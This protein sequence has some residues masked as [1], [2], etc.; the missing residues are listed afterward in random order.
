VTNDQLADDHN[1]RLALSSGLQ[2]ARDVRMLTAVGAWV[3]EDEGG[4][5]VEFGFA[6]REFLFE[7]AFA[8][9]TA[10]GTRGRYLTSLGGRAS[11]GRF[12]ASGRWAFDYEFSQNRM[13]G[14]SSANDDLPQHRLRFSRDHAWS[15]W[16]LSWRLEALVYDDENALTLGLYLQRSHY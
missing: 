9:V 10:F 7:R 13:D 8:D 4:G 11:I 2:L 1:E 14:F 15:A 6:L 3:D 12:T 5:D 16:N